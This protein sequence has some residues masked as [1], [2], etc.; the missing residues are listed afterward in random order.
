M[1]VKMS[2]VFGPYQGPKNQIL[3]SLLESES[4]QFGFGVELIRGEV[5]LRRVRSELLSD[6]A[7][8]TAVI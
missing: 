4:V 1:C 5:V 2:N 8:R 6:A 7:R 3:D